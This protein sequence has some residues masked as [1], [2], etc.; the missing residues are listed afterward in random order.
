MASP[1]AFFLVGS[2]YT[3][4]KGTYEVLVVEND[5]LLVRYDDGSQD[6]LRDL[7]TQARIVNNVQIQTASV[8]P[9]REGDQRN[10]AFFRIS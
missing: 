4:R 5:A 3:N 6:V 8:S 9:Y 7:A 10:N 2:R 1:S